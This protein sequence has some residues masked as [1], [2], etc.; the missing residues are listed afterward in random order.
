[1]KRQGQYGRFA[2][3]IMDSIDR[4]VSFA[5]KYH[6]GFKQVSGFKPVTSDQAKEFFRAFAATTIVYQER[7]EILGFAV[8]TEREDRIIFLCIAVKKEQESNW[9]AVPIF[10]SAVEKLPDKAIYYVGEDLKLRLL[11]ATS[12]HSGGDHDGRRHDRTETSK[13]RRGKA[14]KKT[15]TGCRGYAG[16]AVRV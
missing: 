11:Y 2:V 3:F 12:N 10:M 16:Q 6:S 9:R 8:Y 14:A 4:L 13:G 7:G 5:R 1:L 15:N